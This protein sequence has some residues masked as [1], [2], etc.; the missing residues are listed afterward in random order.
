MPSS[1]WARIL[2]DFA[3]RFNQKTCDRPKAMEF[4]FK[5]YQGMVLSYVNK[6]S[7]MNNMQSQEIVEEICLQLEQTKPY[8]VDRWKK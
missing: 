2:F 8:L 1:L 3:I 5:M 4:L 6:T 7:S